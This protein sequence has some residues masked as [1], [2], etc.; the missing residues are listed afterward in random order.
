MANQS[1]G[2][3]HQLSSLS[4]RLCLREDQENARTEALRLTKLIAAG[5]EPPETAAMDLAYSVC[6]CMRYSLLDHYKAAIID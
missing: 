1:F 4:S 3:I 5:L 2:L 6:S